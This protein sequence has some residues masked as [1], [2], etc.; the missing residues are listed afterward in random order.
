M[1]TAGTHILLYFKPDC[2]LIAV[3][4]KPMKRWGRRPDFASGRAAQ[5]DAGTEFATTYHNRPGMSMMDRGMIAFNFRSNNHRRRR[6]AAG[7]AADTGGHPGL[8]PFP[9]RKWHHFFSA[10]WPCPPRLWRWRWSAALITTGCKTHVGCARF[11]RWW[12]SVAPSRRH[13][14][15][16]PG[17]LASCLSAKRRN[18]AAAGMV[19][20][21]P[22]RAIAERQPPTGIHP[23][24]PAG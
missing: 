3:S 11:R 23:A 6:D 18:C 4:I 8:F 1:K 9:W 19:G 17:F 15:A 13:W 10:C 21:Y 12:R 16:L 2:A 20:G 7:G 24:I 22:L 14:R 5:G